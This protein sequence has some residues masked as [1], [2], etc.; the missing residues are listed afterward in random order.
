VAVGLAVGLGLLAKETILL[1]IGGL[2]VGFVANRQGRLLPRTRWGS[3]RELW[4]ARREDK[5]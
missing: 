5:Q 4:Q 2:A 1:L 3:A